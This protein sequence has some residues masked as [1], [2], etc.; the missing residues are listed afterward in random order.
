MVRVVTQEW[1]RQNARVKLIISALDYEKMS[2]G[3]MRFVESLEEQS[4]S[5]KVL[6]DKQI[7]VLEQIYRGNKR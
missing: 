6:S 5:G 7:H 3:T 4:Q 1:K 2:D